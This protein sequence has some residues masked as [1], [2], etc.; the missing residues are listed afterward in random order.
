[1]TDNPQVV[2]HGHALV[3][4]PVFWEAVNTHFPDFPHIKEMIAEAYR[5]E[6]GRDEPT[7][8]ELSSWLMT[9]L[10]QNPDLREGVSTGNTPMRQIVL[11]SLAIKF[12]YIMSRPC[13]I[14]MP[15]QEVDHTR[16][17]LRT[18][19]VSLQADRQS[20]FKKAVKAHLA[21][22][23]EDYSD[24]YNERLCVA[25]LFVMRGNSRA[26]DVDNM[27]K[28]L[29]DALQGFAYHNDK[30]IDHLDTVRLNSGSIDEAYIGV[31]IARTGS[32]GNDDVIWPEFDAKWIK[33]RGIAPIDLTPFLKKNRPPAAP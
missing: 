30:Q 8:R 6:T 26:T 16:F 21:E 3:N 7:Q 19:P 5:A 24:F 31:R 15:Y 27:A 23:N 32:A 33:T 17:F 29:L 9:A 14:C 28:P 10:R 13:F 18:D 4:S 12:D 11:P 25:V 2:H 1:M 20:A 22:R